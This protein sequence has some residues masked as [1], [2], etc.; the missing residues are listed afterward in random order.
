VERDGVIVTDLRMSGTDGLQVTPLAREKS[1]Q[2]K[3]IVITGYPSQEFLRLYREFDAARYLVKP[4]AI[5]K[6]VR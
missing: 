3:L 6:S 1:P 2:A 4:F 5:G